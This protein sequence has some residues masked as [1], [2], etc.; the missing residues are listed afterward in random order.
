M[1]GALKPGDVVFYGY[2]PTRNSTIHHVGIYLGNGQMVNAARPGTRVRVDSG[3][4]MSHYAG[5][6]RIL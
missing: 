6:A 1:I 5:G 2:I 3:T 4:S